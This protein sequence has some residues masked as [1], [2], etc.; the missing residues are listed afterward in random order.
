MKPFFFRKR[1]CDIDV[2][3]TV[4]KPVHSEITPAETG[5]EFDSVL[6]HSLRRLGVAT[7]TP[8]PEQRKAVYSIYHGRDVFVWL[9]TGFGITRF[10]RL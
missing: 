6:E 9:P 7:I 4:A 8:K 5:I 2:T 10:Y 3:V 1:P